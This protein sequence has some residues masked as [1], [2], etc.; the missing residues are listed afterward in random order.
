MNTNKTNRQYWEDAV[1]SLFK[2][3]FAEIVISGNAELDEVEMEMVEKEIA[4]TIK[5]DLEKY[6]L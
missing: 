3:E 2:P 4:D 1:V 6:N 5:S